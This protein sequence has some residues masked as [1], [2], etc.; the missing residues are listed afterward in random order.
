MRCYEPRSAAG[1]RCDG[2]ELF[3]D[4]FV[5]RESRGRHVLRCLTAVASADEDRTTR[6]VTVQ[7]GDPSRLVLGDL[8][9]PRA[10]GALDG[11]GP[12]DAALHLHST[13]PSGSG[14]SINA[15]DAADQARS[16]G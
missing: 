5:Q 6:A 8:P 3:P 9:E 10:G 7:N 13:R 16:S 11:D 4:D 1:S 2:V 12:R 14:L 15:A